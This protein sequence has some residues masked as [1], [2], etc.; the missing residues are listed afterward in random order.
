MK[1]EK[2]ACMKC[3]FCKIGHKTT[4]GH[5]LVWNAV[6][7]GFLQI[8]LSLDILDAH[9]GHPQSPTV[10]HTTAMANPEGTEA[11]VWSLAY[12]Y[13]CLRC[14]YSNQCRWCLVPKNPIA[15]STVQIED[16][17][18]I[19]LLCVHNLRVHGQEGMTRLL[20]RKNVTQFQ[21][22]LKYYDTYLCFRREPHLA[23]STVGFSCRSGVKWSYLD[24][25]PHPF[26]P[27]LSI[28][29]CY[30]NVKWRY[31]NHI[32]S[33]IYFCN[34]RADH[35]FLLPIPLMSLHMHVLKWKLFWIIFLCISQL[36]FTV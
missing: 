30:N 36:L 28:L 33:P 22:N 32:H 4:F 29:S 31:V 18:W 10:R 1:K 9:I 5:C 11:R 21:G 12:S 27:L 17:K 34:P 35:W 24:W 13:W 3:N 25:I 6:Q 2:R 8:H 7:N 20:L 23:S 26:F 15:C 14:H 16:T 19:F